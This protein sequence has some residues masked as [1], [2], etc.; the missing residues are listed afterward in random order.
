MTNWDNVDT[1]EWIDWD[2]VDTEDWE[3]AKSQKKE[4]KLQKSEIE[5]FYPGYSII[6]NNISDIDNFFMEKL[7]EIAS[8]NDI[9]TYKMVRDEY[10]DIR[11]EFLSRQ[12]PTKKFNPYKKI[13]P[14]K[15]EQSVKKEQ[16]VKKNGRKLNLTD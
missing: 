11:R 4:A 15:K 16:P 5:A 14:V 10:S 2:N 9:D 12:K 7:N 6:F 8:R 3:E 1:E 13:Q